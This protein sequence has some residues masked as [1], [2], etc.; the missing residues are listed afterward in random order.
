[1][2]KQIIGL[3]L[4]IHGWIHVIFQFEFINPDTSEHI[5]WNGTSWLLTNILDGQIVLLIGRIFWAATLVLFILAGIAVL[6]EHKKWRDIDVIASIVSLSA[7][8]IFW[9]GLVPYPLQYVVGPSVAIVTLIALLVVRW[10]PDS[11]IFETKG[12]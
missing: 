6:K 8:I 7:F 9:D 10:P 5:G 12:E 4:I 3:L 1:M 11:W 2:R